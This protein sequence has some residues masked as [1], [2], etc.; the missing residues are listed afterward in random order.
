MPVA[1]V[2]PE[3][4][5]QFDLKT[6]PPDGFIKARPLPYGMKLTRRDKATK[7]RMEIQG[8]KGKSQ[9]Q[10]VDLETMNEWSAAFD[11]AYCIGD[12][13]L[14]DSN[15]VNLDFTN[16]MSLKL[17][18]P[19]IGTE[20]EEILRSLNEDEDEESLEDFIAQ[21]T[22]SSQEEKDTPTEETPS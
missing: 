2:N 12:H 6:A 22:G 16:P 5:E 20:I 14:T 15:G 10:Q 8:G 4:Y 11:F 1:V 3:G 19:K 13:N 17:L 9:N 18:N 7:M 21:H